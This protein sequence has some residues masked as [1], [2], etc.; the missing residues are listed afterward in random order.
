M[1]LSIEI[2]GYIQAKNQQR[3]EQA[4]DNNPELA[5]GRT[6]QGI[7]LLT[8]AAYC[9]NQ[10]AVNLILTRKSS[11]DLYEAAAVGNVEMVRRHLQNDPAQINSFA[12]DG[13]T[14]LSLACYFGYED[15][16][17][18]L[19]ANGAEVNLPSKNVFGSC[20][21]H[22]ACAV[23]HIPIV[24]QLLA[25]QANVHLRQNSGATALHVAAS[26]AHLEVCKLLIKAGAA[27]EALNASRQTPIQLAEDKGHS[28]LVAYFRSLKD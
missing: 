28:E 3:L 13:F 21:L 26:R 20:P 11:M 27:V 2:A 9:R 18:Y 25:H 22:S 7:T 17:S 23:G 15:L 12:V 8:L 4:I 16:V 14:P 1:E 19:L 10:Q 6:P 24:K 5:E